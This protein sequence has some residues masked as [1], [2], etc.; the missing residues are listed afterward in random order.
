MAVAGRNTLVAAI[1]LMA[2]GSAAR[3]EAAQALFNRI[4][5][6]KSGPSG[7]VATFTMTELPG[8]PRTF[9]VPAGLCQPFFFPAQT[10]V[11]IQE[12]SQVGLRL[13]DI[14]VTP[15]SAEISGTRDVTAGV[16]GV[17]S[18]PGG[19]TPE[20][21]R[22]VF[23][24][25]EAPPTTLRVCKTG[26]TLPTATAFPFTAE[27]DGKT[28]P[29]SLLRDQ[30]RDLTFPASAEVIVD[31]DPPPGLEV[32]QI[33]VDPPSAEMNATRDLDAGT[34]GLDLSSGL[35]TV[36]YTNAVPTPPPAVVRVCKVAGTGV[37]PGMLFAF[38]VTGNGVTTP[39]SVAA[40]GGCATAHYPAGTHVTVDEGPQAGFGVSQI[41]VDPPTAEV[42]GTRVIDEGVV[43]LIASTGTTTITYT[44]RGLPPTPLPFVPIS[45]TPTPDPVVGPVFAVPPLARTGVASNQFV[46]LALV[47][48]ALGSGVLAASTAS[49]HPRSDRSRRRRAVPQG[50]KGRVARPH[51]WR[52]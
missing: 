22:V 29:F 20:T 25:I 11:I 2:A 48:C 15:S 35:V 38:N 34:V 8:T 49:A 47:L 39:L 36:T 37:A 12:K 16:I 17:R 31:E 43:G 33:V 45:L 23:H 19:I 32:S 14:F 13:S 40:S 52:A 28:T 21:T 18:T 51:F 50:P 10:D 5:V 27:A 6:C 42:A 1:I 9:V 7:T 41:A 26:A 3:A 4:E 46:L 30:C 24:N 44:N